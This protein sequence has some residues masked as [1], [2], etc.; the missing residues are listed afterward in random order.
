MTNPYL[1]E[2]QLPGLPETTNE[3]LSM[4]LRMRLRCKR[5]WKRTVWLLVVGK[6][7]ASPL[8]RARLTLIRCSSTRPDSDGLV[9][10]F[11]HVIDGLVEARVLENDRYEN[12]GFPNYAWE[13]APSGKGHCK[14]RIEEI[15]EEEA[16]V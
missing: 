15:S 7:P 3:I 1:L 6:R 14:I 12:I 5:I 4:R 16:C 11:K 2:F 8:K 10:S 13:K 9:S